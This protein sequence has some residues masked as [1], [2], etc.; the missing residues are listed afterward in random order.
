MVVVEVGQDHVGHGV[1]A[2][3]PTVASASAAGAQEAAS[4]RV[5]SSAPKPVSTTHVASGADDGPHEVVHRHRGVVRIAAEEVLGLAGRRAPRTSPR[6]PGSR[7]AHASV[8]GLVRARPMEGRWM[9]ALQRRPR[10]ADP[11]ARRGVRRPARFAT[12]DS[13]NI[14]FQELVTEYCWGGVWGRSGADRPAAQPQQPLP[15]RRA[16]PPRGVQDALPGS[17]AQRLHARRAARHPDPDHVYA[18]VPAGV[19]AFRLARQ[20]LEAEGITPE[21]AP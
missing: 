9:R 6:R 12:A 18:G 1:A 17:A 21:P 4:A 10:S 19:E 20:V 2:S 14:E 7:L 3:T 13:F 16:Q 11:R 5:A 15:A 8:V